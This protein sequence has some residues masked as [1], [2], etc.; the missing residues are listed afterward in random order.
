[1]SNNEAVKRNVTNGEI[2]TISGRLDKPNQVIDDEK[3]TTDYKFLI[4]RVIICAVVLALIIAM[5]VVTIQGEVNY[6]N[7][8]KYPQENLT[9]PVIPLTTSAA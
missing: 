1:M 6:E 2:P 9:S 3:K 8:K 7:S 4:V 5:I